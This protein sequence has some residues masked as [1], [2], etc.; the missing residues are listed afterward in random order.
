MLSRRRRVRS[1]VKRWRISLRVSGISWAGAGRSVRSSAVMTE[2]NAWASIA[3]IV[4]GG[5]EGSTAAG[6]G[7][8][9]VAEEIGKVKI[10]ASLVALTPGARNDL[11]PIPLLPAGSTNDFFAREVAPV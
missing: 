7:F 10:G 5:I 9:L 3:R 1:S 4:V 8:G 6:D 2:R 11:T